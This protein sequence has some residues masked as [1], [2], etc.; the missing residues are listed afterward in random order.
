MAAILKRMKINKFCFGQNVYFV[1]VFIKLCI[2]CHRFTFDISEI[3]TRDP[4]FLVHPE[5]KVLKIFL[6]NSL[7]SILWEKNLL[8]PSVSNRSFVI[9]LGHLRRITRPIR[10]KRAHCEDDVTTLSPITQILHK[11]KESLVDCI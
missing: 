10:C 8:H 1:Q 5:R 9:N 6:S 3:Q 11:F 2:T 7:G 4:Q